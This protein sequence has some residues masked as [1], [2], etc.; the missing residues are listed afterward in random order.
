M[1]M[2]KPKMPESSQNQNKPAA[3]HF[4]TYYSSKIIPLQNDTQALKLMFPTTQNDYAKNARKR[5]KSKQTYSSAFHYILP[6][7]KLYKTTLKH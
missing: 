7:H 4:T 6:C 5:P 1:K 2:T 3:V